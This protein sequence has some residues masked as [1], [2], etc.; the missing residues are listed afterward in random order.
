MFSPYLNLLFKFDIVPSEMSL[1]I[2]T[3]LIE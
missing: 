3:I 1:K 2:V